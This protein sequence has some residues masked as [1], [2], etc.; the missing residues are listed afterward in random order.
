MLTN[1]SLGSSI[2]FL[3]PVK[4]LS[5]S[6][7]F[8]VFPYK[9]QEIRKKVNTGTYFFSNFQKIHPKLSALAN[10]RQ[11]PVVP[12]QLSMNPDEDQRLFFPHHHP[13]KI[14]A[15][16]YFAFLQTEIAFLQIAPPQL[17]RNRDRI[18]MPKLRKIIQV[19]GSWTY[20]N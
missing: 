13:L 19:V 16:L 12:W 6:L 15:T 9:I 1:T 2:V 11:R 14:Q 20:R 8:L 4:K 7:T 18:V 3:Q 10:K 5:S 17:M